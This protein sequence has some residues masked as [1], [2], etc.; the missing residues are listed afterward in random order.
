MAGLFKAGSLSRGGSVAL[1]LACALALVVGL[2][3]TGVVD[4]KQTTAASRVFDR[5]AR[6]MQKALPQEFARDDVAYRDEKFDAS[7]MTPVLVYEGKRSRILLAGKPVLKQGL[8][9][10]QVSMQILAQTENGRYFRLEYGSQLEDP[11]V[12]SLS[13]TPCEQ[14]RCREFTD[15]VPMTE[16]AA[17]N[18]V[19]REP[20]FSAQDFKKVFNEDPPPRVLPA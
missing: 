15:F 10:K 17:K 12:F 6:A 5:V 16:Q 9:D 20:Q 4:S 13:V 19:F 2:V 3:L 1:I 18:W 7:A 8:Y 11:E 14:A